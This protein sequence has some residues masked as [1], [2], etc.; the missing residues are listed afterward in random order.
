MTYNSVRVFLFIIALIVLFPFISAESFEFNT[1]GSEGRSGPS[2]SDC[3]GF[4]SGDNE[5]NVIDTGIQR[6]DVPRS[7]YYQVTAYGAQ[8]GGSDGGL[9]AMIQGEFEFEEGDYL[10]IL[11][12]QRGEDDGSNNFAGGGGSFIEHNGNLIIVA[13][14]GGGAEGSSNQDDAAGL[15]S[16]SG[17][18]GD[19]SDGGCSGGSGGEGGSGTCGSHSNTVGY[20]GAAGYSGDGSNNAEAYL[21]G[22][23]G[24][25][26]YADG[27]YGGG[28]EVSSRSSWSRL[29]GG[30]GYSGGGASVDSGGSHAAGGG[31]SYNDGSATSELSGVNSNHG[32][33][34][35][36]LLTDPAD[37]D[38]QTPLV[39]SKDDSTTP[40]TMDVDF[41]VNIDDDDGAASD[42][43]L[44]YCEL[45]VTGL[46]NG[47]TE[48]Y[49]DS[50]PTGDSCDFE[51][52]ND[53]NSNWETGEEVE[54]EAY[55][56]DSYG[57]TDT[58]SRDHEFPY[59]L[60]EIVD[61]ST[62]SFSE[63]HAFNFTVDGEFNR[64][65][66]DDIL[67]VEFENQEGLE[68]DKE[69][70]SS[71]DYMWRE[72]NG[73]EVTY[74][75][76][77]EPS[78]CLSDNC[79]G[80]FDYSVGDTMNVI[81][82][83]LTDD[84]VGSDQSTYN[85]GPEVP[86]A[87]PNP[88]T[89]P[90]NPA[91][92]GLVLGEDA[93]LNVSVVDAEDDPVNITFLDMDSNSELE[94]YTDIDLGDPISYTWED[95]DLGD[96]EWGVNVSD[97]YDYQVSSWTFTRVISDSFRLQKSIDYR[98]SSLIVTE[99]SRASLLIE[100]VNTHPSE[101]NISSEVSALDGEVTA[102][103][104]DYDGSTYTLDSGESKRLQ[105]QVDAD[106]VNGFAEDT[107]RFNSTDQQIGA[108]TV[109]E[110]PV[111]VRGSEQESRGVPGLTGTMIFIIGLVSV[112]LFGLSV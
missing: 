96:Q 40:T 112:L 88:G 46:D 102:D 49:T 105:I 111:Y 71:E 67:E 32:L 65:N 15:T 110:F 73:Q 26:E 87:P 14:G 76:K 63:E 81:D 53:D 47:G 103:F 60:P 29:G 9:G 21:N 43:E 107:L 31:G 12:G 79:E 66:F 59:P 38:I 22:G 3:D 6:W 104:A 98:Y 61:I 75:I 109:E 36:E 56:E 83:N 7:G 89:D 17:G 39:V 84:G 100:V 101:K 23:L 48:T 28:G 11:V 91:D 64:D 25:D 42:N 5:V 90:L 93:E 34:E 55:V 13:G 16:T 86:N 106:E 45:T 44:E 58:L 24:G 69:L 10:D 99:S 68:V 85:D 1:C 35:I 54:I 80:D 95:L 77:V 74:T 50:N 27:G 52:E 8:G 97:H 92:G 37:P 33:V 51:L 18:A 70:D 30:G 82:V 78:D 19:G 41:D 94:S 4:Y 72:E 108:E 2:Q 57:G 20:Y 62:T